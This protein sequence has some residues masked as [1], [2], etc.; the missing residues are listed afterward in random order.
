FRLTGYKTF[1]IPDLHLVSGKAA[2]LV[3][4]LE[5]SVFE[6][7]E[8]TVSAYAGKEAPINDRALTGAR[9]FSIED[10]RKYAGSYG[11]PA[12]MAIN[13]AGV[14][15]ARDN[16]N[17]III[18]GNSSTGLQWRIDGIEIP[19]PNHFGASGTTGGPVTVVNS[20]LLSN[21]DFLN[22]AFPAEYGNAIAGIFDL[23]MRTGNS[24]N[25]EHWFQLG[26]NGIELGTEGPFLK[27]KNSTYLI[28]YR[29]SFI[30]LINR[31]GINYDEAAAYQDISFKF[32]FPGTA[33]GN[34]SVI[35]IGG[36]SRISIDESTK[37]IEEWSFSTHGEDVEN[38][39][40]MG[41]I[42]FINRI[43][44]NDRTSIYTTVSATA[45]TVENIV[46]TFSVNSR[47]P[48]L[49]ATENTKE[50]KYSANTR[51]KLKLSGKGNISAGMNYDHFVVTYHDQQYSKGRYIQYTNTDDFGMDLFRTFIDYKFLSP[52]IE[53]YIG[54]HGQYFPYNGSWSAEP[55]S[56]IKWK[57]TEKHDLSYGS[58]LHSQ[59]QPKMIYLVE[60]LSGRNAGYSNRSLDF[61]RSLHNILGYN[62]LVNKNLRLKI[63][64]YYQYLYDIPVR[65]PTPAYSVINFGTEYYV[66][67][68]DSLQNNGKGEN[69][70]I[71]LTFERFLNKNF[72]YLAT[73]SLFRSVY[74]STDSIKRNTAY[75][76]R[77]A[78]NLLTGYDIPFHK[79][80]MSLNFGIN[81]TYAGGMPYV[82]YNT[83][84]TVL[85][86][87]VVYDW[88][89]AYTVYNRE[90]RRASFRIGIK[91]SRKK[92]SM[93][94]A[95]DLQYRSN[96]TSIYLR[97]IDVTTGEIVNT[98][99]MGFYPMANMRID[100]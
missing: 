43:Y 72:Y 41:V 8:V 3:I 48:F 92:F 73:V 17:D 49:W 18:R 60:D 26:W 38:K 76:G 98:T 68:K 52:G 42:G 99:K 30:D 53:A 11:D 65:D 31:L 96:Y 33:L 51:Y 64:V 56:G 2:N 83:A 39:A 9:S 12:R 79:K 7:S 91:R 25:R 94:T 77:Y 54:L 81:L 70:G 21:S 15:P 6:I 24:E 86:G 74:T 59:M 13:F 61:T 40:S 90:Y 37:E 23:K 28:S 16:R 97:R 55:R 69:Y 47:T 93:E 58:G 57:I 44:P 19:N 20:N 4:A 78:V 63:D 67:R 32:N 89:K 85:Q 27:K 22:G 1:V 29:Y 71:E 66:E 34:W 5:E 10:T 46:D 36:K 14:L 80:N 100:F 87:E 75:N 45:N 35:G 84:A 62:Y 82:P 50:I 88:D 95:I